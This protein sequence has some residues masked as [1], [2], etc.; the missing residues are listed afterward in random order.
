MAVFSRD[1]REHWLKPHFSKNEVANSGHRAQRHARDDDEGDG[2][3]LVGLSAD[4]TDTNSVF[5]ATITMVDGAPVVESWWRYGV[6]A[7]P[8]FAPY[9]RGV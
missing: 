5:A 1:P 4:P 2:Q 9:R 7:R 6:A 3:T 8:E